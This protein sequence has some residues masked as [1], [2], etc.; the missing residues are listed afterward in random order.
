[1]KFDRY[2]LD[3]EFELMGRWFIDEEDIDEGISGILKYSPENIILDLI[4]AFNP[5]NT[6]VG[7]SFTTSPLENWNMYMDLLILEKR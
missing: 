3:K 5:E 2:R 1:M 6:D 4:G 7:I